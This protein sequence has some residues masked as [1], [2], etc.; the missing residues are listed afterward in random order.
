MSNKKYT[1]PA[2]CS[3]ERVGTTKRDRAFR[4]IFQADEG[5]DYVSEMY[6]PEKGE[7]MQKAAH[8]VCVKFDWIEDPPGKKGRLITSLAEF[9]DWRGCGDDPYSWARAY[10]KY[11]DCGPW[12]NFLELIKPAREINHPSAVAI[13]R[14]VR[15]KAKL[16]NPQEI[17]PKF[18]QLLS[19][20][21]DGLDPKERKWEHY[22]KLVD[23]Y[24][25]D[26]DK[27][28]RTGRTLELVK[29]TV[30][31]RHLRQPART[32]HVEADYREVY[33][34]DL[35]KVIKEPKEVRCGC[36]LK[37]G[38]PWPGDEA[39]TFYSEGEPEPDCPSCHGTGKV[40]RYYPTGGVITLDPEKCC[41]IQFGSIVEGSDQCSGPFTHMF[42]FWSS[43]WTRDEEFMEKETSYYW[44]RDN[45]SW[46]IVRTEDDEWVVANVWGDIEWEGEEPTED[47]KKAAETA[48]ENDWQEDPRF[49]GGNC[50]AQTIPKM[51]SIYRTPRDEDKDWKAMQLGDTG[52]EIY[53][54]ENDTVFD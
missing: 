5:E 37:D 7:T 47:I 11:T 15:G 45:A 33:Y 26:E 14:C 9:L 35:G 40:T 46:Y 21:K 17:D 34:E 52:A 39:S 22:C 19:L 6:V 13:V 36:Y 18:I 8:R 50:V 10:Y 20:D 54:F 31:E 41:G 28:A 4:L 44:R 12:V 16:M 27:Q 25:A 23:D 51:P 42:P 24:I 2:N 48:I 29:Q 30:A 1:L 3:I 53:T 49:P 32:E 43:E 38:G